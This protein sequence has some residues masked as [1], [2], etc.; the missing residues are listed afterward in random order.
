MSDNANALA[1]H[2][3][4]VRQSLPTISRDIGVEGQRLAKGRPSLRLPGVATRCADR[5]SNK[6][7]PGELVTKIAQGLLAYPNACF[8]FV[9]NH[10]H[11]RVRSLALRQQQPTFP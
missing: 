5:Q 2:K 1:V 6:T 7:P 3:R 8:W 11:R 4:H 9:V 10:E